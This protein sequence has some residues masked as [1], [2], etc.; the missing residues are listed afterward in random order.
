MFC[1]LAQVLLPSLIGRAEVLGFSEIL[2]VHP[3]IYEGNLENF[4]R[5]IERS[6]LRFCGRVLARWFSNKLN[7]KTGATDA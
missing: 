1:L 7:N 3:E 4:R 2:S 6:S 5:P